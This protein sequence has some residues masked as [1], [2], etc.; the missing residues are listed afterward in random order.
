M[1]ILGAPHQGVLVASLTLHGLEAGMAGTVHRGRNPCTRPGR[2]RK[3]SRRNRIPA[4]WLPRGRS[5]FLSY[6]S[7]ERQA[8]RGCTHGQCIVA[9]K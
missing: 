6:A 7:V 2:R 8:G 4:S 9:T 1:L 5:P 3:N